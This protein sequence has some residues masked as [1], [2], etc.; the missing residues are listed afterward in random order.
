MKKFEF[1][2][3][4]MLGLHPVD[5]SWKDILNKID[6]KDLYEEE[7]EKF[8]LEDEP[9]ITLLYGL[10]LNPSIKSQILNH[11]KENFPVVKIVGTKISLFENEKFDVLKFDIDPSKNLLKLNKHLTDNFPYKN[12]HPD[13][14]PHCTIAYIKKGKGKKYLDVAKTPITFDVTE[15]MW[16]EEKYKFLMSKGGDVKCLNRET[17]KTVIITETYELA[18]GGPADKN[19]REVIF[20]KKI[21]PSFKFSVKVYPDGKIKEMD[22]QPGIRFPF[23]VGQLLNRNAETWACVN[24]YLMN[25]KDM[26]GEKKIFGIRT[27]D[28]PQGHEWRHLFPNKFKEGGSL[29]KETYSKWKSLVNMSKSELQKF[30]NSQEGKEAGLSPSEAKKEGIDS[31][32]ESARWI[33][34]MKDTNVSQWTD[35]MWKWAKKQISFIS[36]MRGNKGGLY[37]DKGNKTRKHTS[38][39]IWG[40]NPEKFKQG[41]N[42]ALFTEGE[43]VLVSGS[44][45]PH[46]FIPGWTKGKVIGVMGDTPQTAYYVVDTGKIYESFPHSQIRSFN[47][48]HTEQFNY[49]IGGL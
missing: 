8:G 12:D 28:V 17:G 25:G 46:E 34:K 11:Y 32:R 3:C 45:A 26:C 27:K 35:S 38:L 47:T 20:S 42:V 48:E 9:H 5:V 49:S 36:R 19:I 44:T 13:Y 37:D 15:L 29:D 10:E 14:H 39:L 16:S 43:D 4:V 30:Y 18:E 1:K 7:G 22:V 6:K 23:V 41:G 33:I 2:G 31:G 40:H 24:G 21:N